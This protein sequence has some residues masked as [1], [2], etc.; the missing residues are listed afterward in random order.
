MRVS[1]II[2]L[3][4]ER[5]EFNVVRKLYISHNVRSLSIAAQWRALIQI[6]QTSVRTVTVHRASRETNTTEGGFFFRAHD[7]H[8]LTS[9]PSWKGFIRITKISLTAK[10]ARAALF[11]SVLDQ[12]ICS[13]SDNLQ[14]LSINNKKELLE[15]DRIAFGRL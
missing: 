6:L 8:S 9:S 10:L 3:N 14:Y 15:P 11:D 4:L 13:I 5:W 7:M 1:R 12:I 2:T